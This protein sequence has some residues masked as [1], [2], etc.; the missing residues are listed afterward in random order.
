[1]II[2]I[3][4]TRREKRKREKECKSGMHSIIHIYTP[5]KE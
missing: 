3:I 1:M 5:F 4:E 2:I